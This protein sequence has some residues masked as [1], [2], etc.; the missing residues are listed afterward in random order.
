M[1]RVR[2]ENSDLSSIEDSRQE[3]P[4]SDGPIL[5]LRKRVSDD[6]VPDMSADM[7][8]GF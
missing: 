2:E 1:S 7:T 6:Q 5:R 4:S 3:R 8:G